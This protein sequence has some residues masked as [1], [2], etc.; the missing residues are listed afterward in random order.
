[1]RNECSGTDPAQKAEALIHSCF[2]LTLDLQALCAVPARE[3]DHPEFC[4]TYVTPRSNLFSDVPFFAPN[5]LCEPSRGWWAPSRCAGVRRMGSAACPGPSPCRGLTPA[6]G[7]LHGLR[8]L[9]HR[10]WPKLIKVNTKA[11]G[12]FVNNLRFVPR[13]LRREVDETVVDR[14]CRLRGFQ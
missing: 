2:C 13:F 4:R 10:L 3:A 11:G 9:P 14:I 12:A 8:L 7:R 1:M 5:P 6:G